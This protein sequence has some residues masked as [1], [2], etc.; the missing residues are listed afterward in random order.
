[1]G[2]DELVAHLLGLTHRLV[3]ASVATEFAPSAGC[4]IGVDLVLAH[5]TGTETLDETLSLHRRC[6]WRSVSPTGG[7]SRSTGRWSRPSATP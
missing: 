6:V 7:S 5:L 2:R 1:M 3:E 4:R